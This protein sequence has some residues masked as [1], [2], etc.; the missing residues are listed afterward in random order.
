MSACIHSAI[1]RRQ[2]RDKRP[3]NPTAIEA[4]DNPREEPD[5]LT[6]VSVFLSNVSCESLGG[7]SPGCSAVL[8]TCICSVHLRSQHKWSLAQ[9]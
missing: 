1:L 6:V 3:L 7:S 8:S 2:S 4:I 5:T 9:K